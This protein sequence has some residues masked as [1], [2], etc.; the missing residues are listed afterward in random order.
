M[1]SQLESLLGQLGTGRWN[2]LH[3][4]A[5]SYCVSLPS[6][7]TLAGAFLAPMQD[8]QC[9]PPD[10]QNNYRDNQS[11]IADLLLVGSCSYLE[12][13]RDTGETS[14]R[15]CT[16][17]TFDNT[18]F[19]STVTSEYQLVC[20]REYLRA[21]YTSIYMFGVLVGAW[22]NGL[23]ADKYG[24]RPTITIGS[25]V[26]ALIAVGSCWVTTLSALLIC[27]FLLG[28]MHATILKTGYIL[29]MEV[30]SPKVRSALG[31]MMYLPWALGT[32]AWGGAAYLLRDWRWLQLVVSL[33]WFLFLPTLFL[34]EESPRWLAV[35]GYH[36][37]ALAVIQRAARWNKVTLPPPH[38]ILQIIKESQNEVRTSS[39]G[40]GEACVGESVLR[41]YCRSAFILVRTPRLR[42]ITLGMFVNYLVVG[43]VYY[44]LSL[45]GNH[46]S[47]DPFVY[48]VLMGLVEVPAY[49]L[50]IPVVIH[51][52]RRA[53]TII[54]FFISAFVLLCLPF[55]PA[56]CGWVMVTLA[57]AGKTTITSAFQILALY[58]S[59]LFPTEVR[60][61]GASTAFMMSRVGS[62]A[63]PFITEY[64]GSVYPW[65]PSVV[66]GVASVVAGVATLA[67]P[68]TLGTALP[69]TIAHL[70]D[71]V[72]PESSRNLLR[73]LT[74]DAGKC[75]SRDASSTQHLHLSHLH[76]NYPPTPRKH[77]YY[78]SA[79]HQHTP[80]LTT[81]H[82]HTPSLTTPHQHTPSLTTPH[83]HTPSLT[84]PHQH[85]PSLT[86]SHQHT[87]SL[88]TPHQHTPSLT[89]PHQHTPSLTTPQQH[90]TYPLAHCYHSKHTSPQ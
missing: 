64:L 40:R 38:R 90:I 55:I 89:T 50:M 63:S 13:N 58:S 74:R 46:L 70:E 61:R 29:A 42:I 68:E 77:S 79:S 2:M 83:Q 88:T 60:T 5:L 35:Q 18:T 26:Y 7:H 59:E 41:G 78:P 65:A 84:T 19:A 76:P 21:T 17:W 87:P 20:G 27:R 39:P 73:L 34:L 1:S 48:M 56:G 25:V 49:T 62:M 43:M 14:R 44:G 4:V 71:K 24:R 69:D 80:S 32:M 9:H 33:P 16:Q 47:E 66:F 6:Y 86:T 12:K 51:Y 53:P 31:I 3:F 82:Q 15:T 57:M 22:F 54:F 36:S 72:L 37:Y 8:Y 85:T 81:S 75:V 11:N 30:S 10:Y 28:T 45:S 23:L 67:L 52:G